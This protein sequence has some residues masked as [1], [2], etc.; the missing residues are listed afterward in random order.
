MGVRVLLERRPGGRQPTP[1][2][3]LHTLDS[4]NVS[5]Q[6]DTLMMAARALGRTVEIRFKKLAE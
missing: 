6:L 3:N 4:E 2:A 1:T 5:V